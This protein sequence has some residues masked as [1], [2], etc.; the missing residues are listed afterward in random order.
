MVVKVTVLR[1]FMMFL[2]I[3]IRGTLLAAVQ[4]ACGGRMRTDDAT[5]KK[6]SAYQRVPAD[7]TLTD[8]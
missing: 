6:M 3:V 4:A 8:D 1:R 2:P 5:P 7:G